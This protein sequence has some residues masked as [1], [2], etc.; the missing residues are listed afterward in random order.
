[1]QPWALITA[2]THTCPI[3]LQCR[4]QCRPAP[5]VVANHAL[6]APFF[7]PH[8]TPFSLARLPYRRPLLL[9]FLPYQPLSS[10]FFNT[11]WVNTYGGRDGGRDRGTTSRTHPH[12]TPPKPYSHIRLP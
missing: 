4:K 7:A 6:L 12:A 3:Y 8:F 5:V 10:L 1:M 9:P 11:E 2:S